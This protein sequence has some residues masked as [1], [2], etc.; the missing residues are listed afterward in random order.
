[1]YVHVPAA[2]SGTKG[3]TFAMM[4]IFSITLQAGAAPYAVDR[5]S[6]ANC[7]RLPH[8]GTNIIMAEG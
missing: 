5:G 6:T 7:V 4:S 3:G 8:T 2:L 1:M